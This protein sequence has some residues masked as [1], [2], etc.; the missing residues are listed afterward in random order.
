[1]RISICVAILFLAGT[2]TRLSAQGDLGYTVCARGLGRP[3]MHQLSGGKITR[4]FLFLTSTKRGHFPL[5]AIDRADPRFVGV[6]FDLLG[7]TLVGRFD[8][9]GKANFPFPLPNDPAFAGLSLL[10]QAIE[11]PGVSGRLFR[12][13]SSVVVVPL[14]LPT[15]WRLDPFKTLASGRAWA[16]SIALRDD[17]SLIC[18]GGRGG[19]LALTAWDSTEV[20]DPA[21]RTFSAGPR[22]TQARAVYRVVDLPGGRSMLLGGVDAKNDPQRTCD[23]YDPKTNAFT[24]APPMFD[25]RTVH[26]ATRLSD[27]RIF[28]AGGL[29]DL[30]NQLTALGSALASTELFDPKTGK[31]SKGPKMSVPRAGHTARL[32]PDGRVVIVG[33]VSWTRFIIKIPKL[34]NSVD[35]FDPKTGRISRLAPMKLARAGHASILLAGNRLLVAGGVG[36]SLTN[37]GTKACEIL[38]LAKNVWSSTGSLPVGKALM[39]GATLG[40]GRF[41]LFGGATGSLL[42]PKAVANCEAFDAASGRWTI[43]PSLGT[44]RVSQVTVRL[45]SCAIVVI[46]G[47]TGQPTTTVRTSELIYP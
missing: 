11:F 31:W 34:S 6:G 21:T 24:K 15:R 22:M 3:V 39:G 12:K 32:L 47:G 28:V 43:L 46:G 5:A 4:Q 44:P 30:N 38:D 45:S 29:S 18:G 37:Q 1:M 25:K 36:G 40:D 8:I 20:Y 16:D 23:Y 13:M 10:H 42:N 17:K 27:G 41:A 2:V 26:T 33:G 35:V 9:R 7:I 19:L 14:E